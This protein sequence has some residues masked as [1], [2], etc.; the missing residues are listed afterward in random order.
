[1]K[2]ISERMEEA[3]LKVRSSAC[4]RCRA[5]ITVTEEDWKEVAALPHDR[6]EAALLDLAENGGSAGCDCHVNAIGSFEGKRGTI[7]CS[8]LDAAQRPPRRKR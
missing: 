1:M 4:E 3:C 6:Q 2:T 7:T 8:G 5:T